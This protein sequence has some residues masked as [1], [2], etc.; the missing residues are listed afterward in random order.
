MLF[1]SLLSFLSQ[2]CYA[3]STEPVHLQLT[4]YNNDNAYV[5]RSCSMY[6]FL[7]LV[8]L[9]GGWV[10]SFYNPLNAVVGGCTKYG[11]AQQHAHHFIS[12]QG[13]YQGL[14]GEIFKQHLCW[15]A[16]VHWLDKDVGNRRIM[17]KLKEN[18]VFTVS[19][20]HSYTDHQSQKLPLQVCNL[21]QAGASIARLI[22]GWFNRSHHSITLHSCI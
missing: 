5:M 1:Q 16:S 17:Q 15:L 3:D 4:L 21:F 7:G 8:F 14:S 22:A 9:F 2:A 6:P 10:H 20:A 18:N 19:N 12:G 13:P 11:Q